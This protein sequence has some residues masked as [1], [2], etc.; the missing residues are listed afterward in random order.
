[1]IRVFLDANVFFAASYSRTGASRALFQMALEKEITI[2]ASEFVLTEAE[3]NLARK[4]PD[5]L[6]AFRQLSE[7][8]VGE[9]VDKP[10]REELEQAATYTYSKTHWSWQPRSRLS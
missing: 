6:P 5:A 8:V 10:T 1:M 2:V 4:A 7:L 3:R 9:I